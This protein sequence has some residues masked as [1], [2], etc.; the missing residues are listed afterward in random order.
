MKTKII[1]VTGGMGTGKSTV[2]WMF[3]KL[4][5]TVIDADELAHEALNPGSNVWKML[6]KRYGNAV[7]GD[8]K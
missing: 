7:M 4:G 1:A 8:K 3:V 5:L 6:F 2:S